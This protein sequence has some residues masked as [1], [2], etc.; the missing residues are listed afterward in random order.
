MD[1]ITV[2]YRF[3]RANNSVAGFISRNRASTD[4]LGA[5]DRWKAGATGRDFAKLADE[6]GYIDVEV[7]C[8]ANDTDAGEQLEVE[9]KK[10][11]VERHVLA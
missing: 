5:L 1:K 8:N 9:S 3:T 11:G 6:D 4:A 7:T 2:R 10:L